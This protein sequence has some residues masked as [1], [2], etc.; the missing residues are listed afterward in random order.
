M[1]CAAIPLELSLFAYGEVADK[2]RAAGLSHAI[3]DDGTIDM[4][5]LIVTCAAPA[6]D[7]SPECD[8]T[9]I[10]AGCRC[11]FAAGRRR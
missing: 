1:T 9:D 11:R 5:G 7:P 2:I 10:C 8:P 6:G 3:S 4:E